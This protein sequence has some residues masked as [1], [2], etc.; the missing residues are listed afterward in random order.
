MKFLLFCEF[1]ESFNW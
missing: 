1:I